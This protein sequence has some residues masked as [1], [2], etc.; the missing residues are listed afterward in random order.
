MLKIDKNKYKDKGL[1]GLTNLG[2]TCFINSCMQVLSNTHELNEFL[3]N[4]QYKQKL[5]NKPDS[6]ILFE[7]DELRKMLWSANLVI[8]PNKF[9][10]TIHKVA[11]IKKALLFTDYS[12]NDVTEFLGFII[13]CFHTAISREVSMNIEGTSINDLDELAILCFNKITKMYSTDYSEILDIFYGTHVSY[14]TNTFTNELISRTPEPFFTL[15]LPI[16]KNNKNVDLLD[17]F[18]L[19]VEGE[20]IDNV[21]VESTNTNVQAKKK[22][23]FW[24]FPNILVIVFKRFNSHNQKNQQVIQF[25]LDN[26]DLSSYVIGYNKDSFHYDLYGICNHSGNVFGGHYTSFIK[27]AN[28]NWYHYNDNQVNKI[29]ENVLISPKAYCLFYRKKTIE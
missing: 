27:N 29:D 2:N 1:C 20:I 12:Q 5:K 10:T 22:I 18:N 25:P 7:W 6:V 15:D 8:S 13:D 23:Q 17:C 24:N 28:G 21:F 14:L 11:K 3:N 9:I 26:L 19:Y 4:E 16:P